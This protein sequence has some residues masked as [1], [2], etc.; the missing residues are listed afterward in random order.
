MAYRP[1]VQQGT[2]TKQTVDLINTNFADMVSKTP[3]AA[4]QIN[5]NVTIPTTRTLAVTDADKLLVGSKIVPQKL[6]L[7][8]SLPLNANCVD[9]AIFIADRAYKVES[10]DE[11]HAVAGDHASAVSLQVTKDTSTNA[12]GAG[13]DLLTNNTNAGFNLKATANTVQNGTLTATEASL[14][15]AVGN[16]LSLDFAG[17][18]QNLAGV[19][20]TITLKLV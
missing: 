20:V 6:I 2:L 7:T 17:D 3:G 10:V 4:Q 14:T 13:T 5:G 8:V 12:P 1:V 15:L 11:V 9:Q 16:R 19:V 18:V